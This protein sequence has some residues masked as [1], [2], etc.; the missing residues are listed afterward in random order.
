MSVF[1][2]VHRSS[3][4]VSDPFRTQVFDYRFHTKTYAELGEEPDDDEL[5]DDYGKQ[6]IES[7]VEHVLHRIRRDQ[8]VNP[9]DQIALT[10]YSKDLDW[11]MELSMRAYHS[12]SRFTKALMNEVSRVQQ[13]KKEWALGAALE[14]RVTIARDIQARGRAF[15]ARMKPEL[16]EELLERG[17]M[18]CSRP[19]QLPDLTADLKI[20]LERYDELK[21]RE[22]MEVDAS[23]A[24]EEVLTLWCT[25]NPRDNVLVLTQQGEGTHHKVIFKSNYSL[26]GDVLVLW[27]DELNTR[28]LRVVMPHRLYNDRR[29]TMCFICGTVYSKNHQCQDVDRRL[30]HRPGKKDLI[31]DA[32]NQKSRQSEVE[33]T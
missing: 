33:S 12:V 20:I 22:K 16:M 19:N 9:T 15:Q 28:M 5:D 10:F 25:R 6:W 2:K 29:H 1:K 23:L 7:M 21:Q 18:V 14:V 3:F 11:P 31:L 13:S 32:P 27:Y 17:I 26:N 24:W 30:V 8:D 4:R